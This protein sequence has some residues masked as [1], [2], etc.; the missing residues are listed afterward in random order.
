MTRSRLQLVIALAVG[1]LIVAGG[2]LLGVQ[3]QL[4]QASANHAQQQDIEATNRTY[5]AELDRLANQATKLDAMKSELATLESSVPSTADTATFYKEIDRVAQASGVTV[6]GITTSNAA[7]YTPPAVP[8]VDP[9]VTEAT[10]SPSATA[11]PSTAPSPSAPAAPQP[12]TDTMITGANFSTI[13]VNMDVTGDFAQALAF[14]RGMQQGPRL[15]L[16]NDI[17]SQREDAQDGESAPSTS[18]TLSGYIYVLADAQAGQETP[19]GDLA[20]DG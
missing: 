13:A 14:T 17:T 16:I 3:P 9:S 19:A 12:L 7:A 6:T 20:S 4:A 5:Q 18:W 10:A 8:T 11:E 15:F 2:T 1:V